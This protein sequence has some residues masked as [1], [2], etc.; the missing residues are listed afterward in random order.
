MKSLTHPSPLLTERGK[1]KF[2]FAF[3]LCA[4]LSS[5]IC[6]AENLISINFDGVDLKVVTNFVSKVTGKNFL[7]DDKV[8]GKVTI[9][10]PTKIP[11]DELY[12]VFLSILEVRGF[13]AIPSG[14]ITKIIPA[15]LARQYPG[16]VDIGK[17]ASEISEEDRI[18]TQL[19][20]IEYA[21]SMQLLAVIKPLISQ[22]GYITSYMPTNTIILT[23]ISP[24]I[25]KILTIIDEFDIQ[26]A[27]LQTIIIQLKYA[28]AAQLAEKIIRTAE[29]I[30]SRSKKVSSRTR[31]AFRLIPDERTNSLILVANEKDTLDIKTLIKKLDVP[32]PPGR[33]SVHVYYLENANAEELAKILSNLQLSG[34]VTGKSTKSARITA[35]KSTNSLV[36]TANPHDYEQIRTIIQK[37]DIPRAQVLVEA[38]IADVSMDRLKEFGIEWGDSSTSG[39]Y[40]LTRGTKYSKGFVDSKPAQFKGFESAGLMISA[41]KGDVNIGAL[42][43]AY[44]KDA[45]FNIL[46]TPQLLTLDNK[47][48][49]IIVGSNIPYATQTQ[50]NTDNSGVS[51]YTYKDV[52]IELKITPHIGTK[53]I[54]RL[55]LYLKV[56]K[57]AENTEADKPSTTVRE[58]STSVSVKDGSTIV[59]GGLIRNNKTETIHKVPILGDIPVL[60]FL[61]SRR[62]YTTERRNLMLFI[63]PHV[64]RE[65]D[66]MKKL[67]TEKKESLKKFKEN[68]VDKKRK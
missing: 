38:L 47:E 66:N 6:S 28:D 2:I 40:T 35:D 19:I 31:A 30:N 61:F 1:W 58:T 16:Q 48:A 49:K 59:I 33:E 12:N 37:L 17:K 63:T 5:A 54:V 14:N 42:I 29:G 67:T 45:G 44:Q 4:G 22:R 52:G 57:V 34:Q 27:K 20:P 50:F 41:M 46:S 62:E 56:T 65:A 53:D 26:G 60:G 25:R 39:K 10:S 21:E 55:D 11:V 15:S 13:A 51:S 32:S 64:V 36:V 24:N 7:L 68:L 9:I 18:I 3:V 8:R 43:Q 23:D